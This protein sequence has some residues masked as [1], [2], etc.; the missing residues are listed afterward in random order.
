MQPKPSS[1]DSRKPPEYFE[2]WRTFCVESISRAREAIERGANGPEHAIQLASGWFGNA[3]K[4]VGL[5]YCAGAPRGE[6]AP[7]VAGLVDSCEHLH[8]VE[9]TGAAFSIGSSGEPYLE[10]Y[11]HAAW[12]ASL[13]RLYGDERLLVRAARAIGPRGRD[14][15]LD[16]LLSIE[17]LPPGITTPVLYPTPYGRLVDAEAASDLDTRAAALQRF[18][19]D[20]LESMTDCYWHGSHE[21]HRRGIYFG[22]WSWEAAAFVRM[23]R[24][25]P[26]RPHSELLPVDAIAGR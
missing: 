16:R 26:T 4:A 9:G 23:L 2:R 6:I 19:D 17:P 1:R 25:D 5:A 21:P 18:L 11:V 12:V 20:Y 22:Y 7:L 13:V 3:L 8:S 10:G 15:V 24:V 14:R